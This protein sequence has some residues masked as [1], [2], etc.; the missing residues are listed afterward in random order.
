MFSQNISK[1]T[2]FTNSLLWGIFTLYVV[3]LSFT[4]AHHELWGDEIHSW[5]IAKASNSFSDL[6]SNTRYEG[7][8]PVWYIILWSISKFTH[9]VYYIQLAQG[10]IACAI[11]FLILFFSQIPLL[12]KI[13][14]PFGYFFLFEYGVL[15]RNYAIGILPAFIICIILHKSFPYKI[16]VYYVLLFLLSNTHL[17]ALLLACS[18]HFYFLLLNIEQQKKKSVIAFHILLGVLV[19]L[20]SVYFIFPPQDSGLNTHFFLDRWNINQLTALIQPPLRS[21]IPIPA[22]W[23]YNFWNTQFLL[24]AQNS[25]PLLKIVSAII[26]LLLFISIFFILKKNKKSLALFCF[27]LVLSFIIALIFSLTTPRYAGFIFIGFIVAY[28]LYCYKTPVDQKNK[29]LVN[30]LLAIQILASVFAIIKDIQLPFSNGYNAKELVNEVPENKKIV[31]DYWTLNS[32]EA[33]TDKSFYCLELRKEMSFLMWNSELSA[34][35]KSPGL[36][37]NGIKYFFQKENVKDVYMISIHSP[38]NIAELDAQLP[39]SF[40]VTLV[41][42]KEGAIEKGGNLYLYE[43]KTD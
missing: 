16:I 28:W 13:F 6:I 40:N 2:L 39:K 32:L 22:W 1:Q 41:D 3:I 12:T 26:V 37:S 34:A 23:N 25:F 35:I 19:L 33:F 11:V 31:T 38:Q 18:L 4:I 30:I 36:Y 15:S 21:F 43:I 42:K 27:N 20:P 29:R 9:D 5:N 8:P 24:E 14:I 10:V 17:L 7:H